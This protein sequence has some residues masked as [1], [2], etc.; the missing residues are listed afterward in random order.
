MEKDNDVLNNERKK[1]QDPKS[2]KDHNLKAKRNGN[3]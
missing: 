1:N 3:P 2:E